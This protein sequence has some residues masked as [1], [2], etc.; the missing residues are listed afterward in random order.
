MKIKPID[1]KLRP[2]LDEFLSQDNLQPKFAEIAKKLGYNGDDHEK[3]LISLFSPDTH[4]EICF[5]DPEITNLF[6]DYQILKQL[7]ITEPYKTLLKLKPEVAPELIKL[8]KDILDG[9]TIDADAVLS[10][11][12]TADES[13]IESEIGDTK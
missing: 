8:S 7:E 4:N 10:L 3:I 5:A 11:F 13:E 1:P 6:V 2:L 9:K 12:P